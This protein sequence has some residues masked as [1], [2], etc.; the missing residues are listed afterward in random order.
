L[1][2]IKK[3][4]QQTHTLKYI[5]NIFKPVYNTASGGPNPD[6][7]IKKFFAGE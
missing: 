5:A 6:P 7:P 1:I 3:S 4:R 2:A